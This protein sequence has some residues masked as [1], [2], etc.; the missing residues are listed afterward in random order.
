MIPCF[1]RVNGIDTSKNTAS[2]KEFD[3]NL[4]NVPGIVLLTLRIFGLKEQGGNPGVN[5]V[6]EADVGQT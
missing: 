2:V 3:P 5:A 4:Q 6:A 1:T